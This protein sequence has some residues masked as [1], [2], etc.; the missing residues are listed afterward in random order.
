MQNSRLSKGAIE[1]SLGPSFFLFSKG[2]QGALGAIEKGPQP[3]GENAHADGARYHQGHPADGLARSA[4]R[5]PRRS[6]QM[7]MP[8]NYL[9]KGKLIC[10][11]EKFLKPHQQTLAI[12]VKAHD[13]GVATSKLIDGIPLVEQREIEL[14]KQCTGRT[15]LPTKPVRRL[16]TL[17]G[18]RGGKDRFASAV[19]VWRAALCTDWRKHISAGE[20][21]VLILLGADRK[22]A[23]I[24]RKYCEGLLQVPLLAAEV[25][26]STGEVIEFK[27][28]ASL[29][30]STNDQRLVRGRS[31]IAVLGSECC[32]WRTDEYA[33]S[34][35]EEVVGAWRCVLTVGC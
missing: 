6:R 33:A 22:Q 3:A 14:F 15:T 23:G 2:P 31:A 26:R 19:S 13:C 9:G 21:A 4:L 11:G 8:S 5:H 12:V 28:N 27:N 25:V 29:E 32:H 17:C 35:D 7:R 10:I 18:R 20:Q 30:I 24:L 16:I 34:S 1:I